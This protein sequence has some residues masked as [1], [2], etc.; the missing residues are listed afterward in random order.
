MAWKNIRSRRRI[1]SSARFRYDRPDNGQTVLHTHPCPE[2]G[3]FFSPRNLMLQHIE[4]IHVVIVFVCMVCGKSYH[5]CCT[6]TKHLTWVQ[7]RDSQVM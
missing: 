3:N 6:T 4:S 7:D 2:C 1:C 5:S